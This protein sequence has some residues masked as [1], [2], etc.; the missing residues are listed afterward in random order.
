VIRFGAPGDPARKA[1]PGLF[2][3]AAE[4]R[5]R[6]RWPT[7]LFALLAPAWTLA[8]P[9]AATLALGVG[10]PLA[11]LR[12]AIEAQV[13]R[14]VRQ[15]RGW[16]DHDG[17]RVRYAARRAPLELRVQG[18]G[19]LARALVGYWLEARK[20]VLGRFPVRGSCDVDEPPRAVVLTLM[21]RSGLR[22][23]W[24]L[25][26]RTTVLPLQF[27]KPCRMTFA[28]IDVTGALARALHE[29]LWR[30]AGAE[31]D[32]QVPRLGDLRAAA[33]TAWR[34]LHAPVQVDEGLWLE[35]NP[36]EVWASQPIA[37]DHTLSLV[38]GLAA[39]PRLTDIAPTAAG[40]VPPLPALRLAPPVVPGLALPVRLAL[41]HAD[42]TALV[43]ARLAGRPLAWAGREFFFEAVRLSGAQGVL[44]VEATLSGALA[45]TVRL[46]GTPDYD[47]ET[48]EIVL[49]GVD[50]TLRTEDPALERRERGLHELVRALIEQHARWPLRERLERWRERV[51]QGLGQLLPQPFALR[52]RLTTAR[53]LALR[54]TETATVVEGVLEGEARLTPE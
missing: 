7:L 22:S 32:R 16:H 48:G 13:P 15:D 35:L 49:R 19:L 52:T 29:K 10:I 43:R 17:V 1:R 20:D 47:A 45:G 42:A 26:V 31:I 18:D 36:S 39:R 50:Y 3:V 8:D 41:S 40:A 27:L 21:S 38:V 6:G 28:G 9:P 11:P 54:V 25:A 51:E 2:G 53:P 14:E 24:R 12:A 46:S 30:A 33:E 5:R 4:R 44:A 23:D 37:D 34:R